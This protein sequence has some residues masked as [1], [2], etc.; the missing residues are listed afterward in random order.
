MLLNTVLA[1]TADTTAGRWL[2]AISAASFAVATIATRPP[3]PT[4]HRR[5]GDPR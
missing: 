2:H 1:F 4:I 5:E 3:R